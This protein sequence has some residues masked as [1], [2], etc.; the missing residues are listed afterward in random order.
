MRNAV[1]S[2]DDGAKTVKLCF[3]GAGHCGRPRSSRRAIA[4]DGLDEQHRSETQIQEATILAARILRRPRLRRLVWISL[5][6]VVRAAKGRGA[7]GR[8]KSRREPAVSAQDTEPVVSPTSQGA[9]LGRTSAW[10]GGGA[11]RGPPRD[12]RLAPSLS[13][14]IGTPRARR[15]QDDDRQDARADRRRARD[16]SGREG[17][18][19]SDERGDPG[20]CRREPRTPG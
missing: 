4:T 20:S 9:Q 6:S 10:P 13:R 2:C 17:L 7:F 14:G 3:S 1:P 8:R 18:A 16:A 11:R 15:V 5:L 12:R 19:K